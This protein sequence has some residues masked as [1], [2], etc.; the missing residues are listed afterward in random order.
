MSST[1]S[2]FL[3]VRCAFR[4]DDFVGEK[5]DHHALTV[6]HRLKGKITSIKILMK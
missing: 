5:E 4:E 6:M 2:C 1:L 3:L